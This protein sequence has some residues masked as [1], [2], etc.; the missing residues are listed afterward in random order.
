MGALVARTVDLLARDAERRGTALEAA[1]GPLCPP[2][3]GDEHRL[4]Q[5]LMNLVLNALD[6]AGAGGRVRVEM[7]TEDRDV[8][9]TVDDSGAGIPPGLRDRIFEPFFTTKARGS[10]LGLPIV[11]AIVVQH[12][13]QVTIG[14]APLGGARFAV[15]LPRWS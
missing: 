10:G 12:G 5:V 3:A 4:A 15:R 9:V 11:N 8:V 1:P 13:G 7:L 14:T 2:V 6:A